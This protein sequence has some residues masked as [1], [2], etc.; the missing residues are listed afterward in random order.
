M[1]FFYHMTKSWGSCSDKLP[2]LSCTATNNAGE[3]SH[4]VNA[5]EASQLVILK[6]SRNGS[7]YI[8]V[9]ILKERFELYI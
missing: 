3:G 2:L 9:I 4:T 6:F 1:S 5:G 7:N 8:S